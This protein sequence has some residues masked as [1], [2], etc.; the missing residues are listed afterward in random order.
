MTRVWDRGQW[1]WRT[2]WT[3][4]LHAAIRGS[5][6]K[7]YRAGV[8]HFLEWLDFEYRMPL[9]T[10]R[11]VDEALCEYGWWVYENYA[12]RAKWRLNMAV[13]GVEHYL[14]LL[15]KEMKMARRSL[16]G[17]SNLRPPIS[18]APMSWSLACLVAIELTRMGHPGAAVAGN[19]RN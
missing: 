15:E 17:W 18:H 6:D 16:R 2:A 4:L 19:H 13:F 5:S 12:G 11:E 8:R 1:E 9:R 14:P 7:Q 10:P 3:P